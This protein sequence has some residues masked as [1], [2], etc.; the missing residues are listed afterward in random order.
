[1]NKH[2]QLVGAIYSYGGQEATFALARNPVSGADR[3]TE[4]ERARLDFYSPEEVEALGRALAAGLHRDRT[5]P[6]VGPEESAARAAED[7]QDGELVRVAAY[8][9][10]RRGELVALRWRDVDFTR[11]K[12]VVRRA[13]SGDVEVTSTKSRRARDVPLPDQAAGALDRLSQR[14]DFTSAD[15]YVF[16]NRLG[17]RLD[18]S[19]LRRRVDRARDAAGLPPLRFHDLR[20]TYG[21]Q[22]VARG[23]RPGL[24]EGGHGP[25]ADHDHRAVPARALGLRARRPV[26]PRPRTRRAGIRTGRD[27]RATGRRRV[28]LALRKCMHYTESVA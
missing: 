1:M 26:H 14:G 12:L 7:C 21:S 8:A 27:W 24:G 20:H 17:R 22:L 15:D 16:A 11:R 6:A 18:G 25:F 23:I 5:A 28:M 3:R 10:L 9:G 2:R 4:P 13:V 19:A